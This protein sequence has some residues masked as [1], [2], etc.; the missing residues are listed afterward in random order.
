MGVAV[1][2]LERVAAHV[3]ERNRRARNQ[4]FDRNAD[5]AAAGAQIQHARVFHAAQRDNRRFRQRFGVLPRN[6]HAAVHA[7]AQAHEVGAAEN[8]LQRLAAGPA[9]EKRLEL[10]VR[11]RVQRAIELEMHFRGR[12]VQD[13]LRDPFGIHLRI[14]GA[15]FG[16]R[17]RRMPKPIANGHSKTHLYI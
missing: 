9:L 16:Q 15:G 12:H 3:R 17:I 4:R 8:V 2:D 10:R 13:V 5:R 7:E 6:Q 1:R 14:G 11:V